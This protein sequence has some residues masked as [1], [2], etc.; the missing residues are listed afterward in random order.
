MTWQIQPCGMI[1]LIPV[2]PA[3]MEQIDWLIVMAYLALTLGIGTYLSQQKP[4]GIVSFFTARR[5]VPWWL[6]GVSMAATTLSVDTPL[7]IAGIVGSR[8]LAGN[9]EWWGFG[10]AHVMMIYLFARLWRRAEIVTDAELS[11]IRYGGKNAAIL[12]GVKA[13]VYAVPLNCIGI[14]YSMLAMS[15]VI[16][17]LQLWQSLGV[18]PGENTK[19]W[20]VLGLSFLALIY[21]GFFSLWG[22]VATDLFQFALTGIGVLIVA[23]TA[24]A[25]VGGMRSLVEQFTTLNGPD[26]LSILP[27]GGSGIDFGTLA[28]IPSSTFL[29]Y[30]MLQWWSFRR[31]DGGGEFIQRF[32]AART[33]NEAQKAAWLFNILHYV[34]RTWPLIAIALAAAVLYPNLGDKE[35]GYPLLML[36]YLPPIVLGL[37]VA[38]L[39]AAF[40]STVSTLINWGA[41]YLSNDL[42]GRFI[43]P[44]AT[45]GELMFAGRLAAIVVTMLGAIASF[46]ATDIGTMF[47]LAIA[48][49]TG[50]GLVFILRWFWWRINAAAELAAILSGFV[51][52]LLISVPASQS[53]FSLLFNA[54]LSSAAAFGTRLLIISVVTTF[55]WAIALIFTE[56]ESPET[57]DAFYARVR[58]GG[59]GWKV[60]QQRTRLKPQQNLALESQR[61]LASVLL[62]FGSMFTVGG[63]L[64]FQSL[65]G[66]TSLL[67]ALAGGFWLRHLNKQPNFPMA[68]PGTEDG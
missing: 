34:V 57:L 22:V 12:R 20:S 55:C 15:K 61:I 53:L 30:V 56:P 5:Q 18:E 19:L 4:D 39:M 44:A 42:Y 28:A 62:L 14:G 13:F 32:A 40:L 48:I 10:F 31:S 46:I 27:F 60:Q 16:E 65:T 25:E 59:P 7:Y 29:A 9:W 36:D 17:G 38:S 11:E 37:V 24:T 67:M 2:Q 58:P 41:S 3:P 21:V 33:E 54:D 47:R 6:A 63:F 66:W 8:G 1:S 23:M 52:G 49:G 50:P 45:A 26:S 51:V 64:L 43:A 35:L 68:R